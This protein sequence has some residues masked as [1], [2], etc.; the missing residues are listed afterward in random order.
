[1]QGE[2]IKKPPYFNNTEETNLFT[3]LDSMMAQNLTQVRVFALIGH[4]PQAIV[5]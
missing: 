3:S 1:M 4:G 5:T 2:A